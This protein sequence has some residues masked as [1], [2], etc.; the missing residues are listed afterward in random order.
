VGEEDAD[1]PRS[2][3]DMT[4]SVME[5]NA[6][7]LFANRSLEEIREVEL[8]T[9]RE[10]NEKAEALRCEENRARDEREYRRRARARWRVVGGLSVD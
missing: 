4:T 1:A 9:R 7:A 8:R 3:T 6:E 2:S 5:A 10:A